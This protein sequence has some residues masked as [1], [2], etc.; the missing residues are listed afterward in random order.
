MK[1]TAR[2]AD[3]SV[4]ILLHC[5]LN[6]SH[7]ES[8]F[9]SIPSLLPSTVPVE[10]VVWRSTLQFYTLALFSDHL[11]FK[12]FIRF[13]ACYIYTVIVYTMVARD[14]IPEHAVYILYYV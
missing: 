12:C 9:T 2:V 7:T 8:S 5:K 11:P 13:I 10:V 1:E 14:L 4:I 6:T 3:N